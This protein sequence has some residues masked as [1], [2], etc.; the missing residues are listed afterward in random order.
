MITASLPQSPHQLSSPDRQHRDLLRRRLRCQWH[1]DLLS[2]LHSPHHL[3]P[4][5]FHLQHQVWSHRLQTLQHLR[6]HLHRRPLSCQSLYAH[7]CW[8]MRPSRRLYSSQHYLLHHPLHRRHLQGRHLKRCHRR[9]HDLEPR[10]KPDGT[11]ARHDRST[12]TIECI[13]TAGFVITNS[14]RHVRMKKSEW[15]NECLV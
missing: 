1:H 13:T 5:G 9:R 11:C 8:C 6:R 15:R 4:R 14:L 12:I 10:T 3:T 2:P 7:P